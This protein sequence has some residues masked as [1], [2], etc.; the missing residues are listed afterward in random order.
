MKNKEG[1]ICFGCSLKFVRFIEVCEIT[2]FYLV[3]KFRPISV[4]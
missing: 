4:P 1:N 2:Q 3:R